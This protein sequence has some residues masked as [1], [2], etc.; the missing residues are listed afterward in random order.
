[1]NVISS[2]Q[3]DTGTADPPVGDPVRRRL[4]LALRRPRLILVL[5]FLVMVAGVVLAGSATALLKNGGFDDPASDSVA[6]TNVLSRHFPATQP[7]LSVLVRA[8]DGKIAGTDAQR[9][10][11]QIV[12]TLRAHAGVTVVGSYVGGTDPTMVGKDGSYGLVLAR[13][14]GDDD[15]SGKAAKQLHDKLAGHRDGV[16]V[17][18]GGILQINNDMSD[19]L[20]ADLGMSELVA[21][22]LTLILLF[23]VFRGVI[24]A[25]L[26]LFIGVFAILG[27]FAVLDGLG[28][29]TSISVFALNL[30]TALGLGLAIDYSLLIVSRFREERARGLDKAAALST[31]MRTAGRTVLFSAS[32][33]AAVLLTMLVFKQDFLRSFA[34]AG[35]T[36]VAVAA[37]G[38]LLPLP[39]ALMLLG[40]R[41]DKWSI[42]RRRPA[43]EPQRRLWGR[44][45]GISMRRPLILGLVALAMFVVAASPLRSI[46]L[47]VPDERVLPTSS[48]GRQASQ[49]IRT[50]F[51]GAAEQEGAVAVTTDRWLGDANGTAL[52]GYATAL[53]RL[54]HVVAVNAPTGRYADGARVARP[55]PGQAAAMHTG[56][57]VYLQVLNDVTP[58]S[59]NGKKLAEAVRA[60]P[61]PGD[62]TVRVG[63]MSAQLLDID[64][65]LTDRL[66]L[67]IA[68][69]ILVTMVLL[70]L[71]TGSLLVPIKAVLLNALG[72]TAILGILVWVF[73]QGHLS[74]PLNFTPSPIA[75]SMPVLV[76]CV[77]YGL[78]MDYEVF[79][80]SRIKETYEAT[81]DPR[82]AVRVGLGMSGSIVSA[83]AVILAITFFSTAMSGVS[84]A[85]LFG[86]GA[87]L[88]IVVDATLIRGVLVPIF[89]RLTGRAAW[90][91]PAGM[92]RLSDRIG[93]G[94]H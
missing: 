7:N 89:L 55:A 26:P 88:A 15:T 64:S 2:G 41:V 38:A 27:S 73:Q 25:L 91:S 48:E 80:L 24:A 33:V 68:L 87:G 39:A 19:Q 18:F 28:R 90:W 62:R 13:V 8:D 4:A 86:I 75:V 12:A 43:R 70:F 53:S 47:N 56:D 1:M 63:G 23:F 54:P 46:Q 58:Y 65:A 42:R 61:V 3:L 21:L 69:A 37:I 9:A 81:G 14:A 67:A 52:D 60:T 78:S 32:I 45:A 66:P 59:D 29:L 77:A 34:F 11:R 85:K 50:Q 5:A 82:G 49:T 35:V 44:I 84:V 6:A 76:L 74:G 31:T 72:L 36:V 79:V 92:R 57:A 40:D 51:P 94:H 30:I 93:L 17:T 10:G 71:A 83:A 16:H 20:N 22:P